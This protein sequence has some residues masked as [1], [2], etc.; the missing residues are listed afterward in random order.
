MPEHK[1]LKK[2]AIPLTVVNYNKNIREKLDV[3]FTGL[4]QTT[5]NHVFYFKYIYYIM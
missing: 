2:A 5:H 3:L 1:E 4:H